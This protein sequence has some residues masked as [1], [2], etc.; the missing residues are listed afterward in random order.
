MIKYKAKTWMVFLE[1]VGNPSDLKVLTNEKRGGLTV[2]SFDRSRFKLFSRKFSKNWCRLH[3][4]RGIMKQRYC[5]SSLIFEM[6][7]KFTMWPASFEDFLIK[8][9]HYIAVGK[10]LLISND[11]NTVR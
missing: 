5:T 10:Q 7:V 9:R 4:V 2:E 8:L 6:T 3:P 11:N 1:Q